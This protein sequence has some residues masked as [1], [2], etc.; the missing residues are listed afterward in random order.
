MAV[1]VAG[2]KTVKW[3][4]K[5]ISERTSS[6]SPSPPPSLVFLS[7]VVLSGVMVV[8]FGGEVSLGIMGVWKEKFDIPKLQ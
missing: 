4:D 7:P 5:V 6:P 1:A 3:C 2:T 8:G